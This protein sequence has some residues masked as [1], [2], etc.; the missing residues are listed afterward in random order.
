MNVFKYLF[1]FALMVGQ[2]TYALDSLHVSRLGVTL[3]NQWQDAK[4]VVLQGNYAYVASELSG[5]R[6][7]DIS[8]PAAPTEVG[9]CGT[10]GNARSVIVAGNYAY[11]ADGYEGL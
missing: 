6:V 1:L 4:N 8:N 9:Y 2:H 5:L 7:V 3:T 10:P 11:V